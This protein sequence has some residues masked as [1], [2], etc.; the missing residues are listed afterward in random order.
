MRAVLWAR[1]SDPRRG[2]EESEEEYKARVQQDVE[3]QFIP[4]RDAARRL[5]WVVVRE[6]PSSTGAW[7]QEPPEKKDI[8]FPYLE[9]GNADLVAVW[10]L[11][12]W[13]RKRPTGTLNELA[14]LEQHL[15]VHFYS[16]RQPFLST[17]NE[18]LRE[19]LISI[20]AWLAEEESAKRSERVKAAVA[21][22]RARTGNIGQNPKWG[23]GRIPL[24]AEVDRIR[25]LRKDHPEWSLARLGF[26]TGFSRST[27]YRICKGRPG[28]EGASPPVSKQ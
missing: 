25:T 8:L 23:R 1:V 15:G 2:K 27:V 17:V 7:N 13:T 11:D 24:P 14:Y 20:F 9:A 19:A 28:P 21:A 16:M 5:G 6:I 22:K 18:G 10:D 4:L 12:R 3:N 26:E